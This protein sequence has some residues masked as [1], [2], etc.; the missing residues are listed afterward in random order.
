[1]SK[2]IYGFVLTLIA[3]SGFVMTNFAQSTSASLSGIVTDEK[4]AVI[5]GANVTLT[6]PT[7]NFQKNAITDSSG[8]FFFSQLPPAVYLLRAEN[9]GFSPTE[10][11]NVELNVNDQR[12][13]NVELKVGGVGGTVQV[14]DEPTL[15]DET[16]SVGTTVNRQFVQNLPLNGRSFQSLFELTP[17]VV[18]TQSGEG[19]QGQFSVNGQRTNA[20]YVT[21]DGV[22]ANVS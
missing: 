4:G 17:G 9:K 20:N 2:A 12:T 18:L 21:V 22:S 8:K 13:I 5:A 7:T 19:G 6:N 1:M 3:I 15:L 16:A 14:T 10:I 11:K